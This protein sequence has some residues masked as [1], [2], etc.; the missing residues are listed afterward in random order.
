MKRYRS[1]AFTAYGSQSGST[2]LTA[3]ATLWPC[4]NPVW[5]LRQRDD[6]LAGA[7]DGVN[8]A[9]AGV[10]EHARRDHR[11]L[12]EDHRRVVVHLLGERLLRVHLLEGV[13]VGGGTPYHVL[14]APS[15]M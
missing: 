2:K 10:D 7:L 9:D 12:L 13:G 5:P 11:V 3:S 4:E 1:I 14:G 8:D 15:W 6:E